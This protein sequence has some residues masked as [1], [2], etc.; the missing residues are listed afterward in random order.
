MNL[1]HRHVKSRHQGFVFLPYDEPR[2][3]V[4]REGSSCTRLCLLRLAYVSLP[5]KASNYGVI[6]LEVVMYV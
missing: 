6:I 5:A 4:T 1:C 3:T 2:R